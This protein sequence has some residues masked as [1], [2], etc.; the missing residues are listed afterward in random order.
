[1]NIWVAYRTDGVAGSGTQSDPFDASSHAK[2]DALLNAMPM[3]VSSLTSSGTIATVTAINHGFANGNTVVING[4][5]GISA[6]LFNGSFVITY[7]DANTFTYTMS[8][9]PS[10]APSGSITCRLSTARGPVVGL[11]VNPPLAIHLGPGTFQTNGYADAIATGGWQPRPGMKIVGS[12][13]DVTTLQ[14]A[15]SSSGT[16]A[17][18]YAIGHAVSPGGRPNLLDYFE[19]CDLTIDC[20]LGASTGASIA[21]GAVRVMGNHAKVRRVKV[22]NWGTKSTANPCFVTSVVTASDTGWVEDCG[23]EE[24]I[25]ISP[26]PTGN[27]APVTIFHSGEPESLSINP[28]NYGL[29]PYI[30]NCFADGGQNPPQNPP[31]TSPEIRGLSLA[32]CKGGIMEGNQVHNLTYGVFQQPTNTQD[33]IVRNNWIKNVNKGIFLGQIGPYCPFG[34]ITRGSGSVATFA[35]SPTAAHGMAVGDLVF[36]AAAGAYNGIMVRVQAANFSTTSF[37]FNTALSGSDSG[38]AARVPQVGNASTVGSFT[39]PG[40]LIIEGNTIELQ[41]ATSGAGIIGIHLTDSRLGSNPTQDSAFPEYVFPRVIVRDNKIRY[42]DGAPQPTTG[43]TYIGYGMQ[44][45]SALDLLVRNNVVDTIPTPPPP[46][47]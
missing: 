34:N 2:F 3:V 30:R 12:G 20:N 36:F 29:A 46:P 44:L 43:P 21:S 45:N 39:A 17:H 27:N 26:Y 38:F 24:C 18:L 6:S 19:V 16:A 47:I 4:V 1:M 11:D 40:A 32:W 25:A 8:S 9:T 22:V 7:V 5:T 37:Q 42:L 14:V 15:G 23:I 28:I 13:V 41:L 33:L 31:L 10:S 35:P